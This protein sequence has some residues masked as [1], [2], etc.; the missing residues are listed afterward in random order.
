MYCYVTSSSPPFQT[1]ID[2]SWLHLVITRVQQSGN[3]QSCLYWRVEHCQKKSAPY[4]ML[5]RPSGWKSHVQNLDPCQD[6][7]Q[8][9][10]WGS[11]GVRKEKSCSLCQQIFK[12]SKDVRNRKVKVVLLKILVANSFLIGFHSQTILR[13]FWKLLLFIWW[14]LVSTR[15]ILVKKTS[16]SYHWWFS[17]KISLATDL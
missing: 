11:H 8:E 10:W 6:A 13:R 17:P 2:L 15:I 5:P 7:F 14:G 3:I 12:I 4:N 9:L 1:N 16:S